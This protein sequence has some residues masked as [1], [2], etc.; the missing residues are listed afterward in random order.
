MVQVEL[1]VLTL[2]NLK[3][4]EEQPIQAMEQDVIRGATFRK[5]LG[6]WK[7]KRKTEEKVT[8]DT[9]NRRQSGTNDRPHEL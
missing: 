2:K 1:M 6:E 9:D 4:L 3:R 8:G 5:Q 7:Y